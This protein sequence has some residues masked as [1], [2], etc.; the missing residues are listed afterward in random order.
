MQVSVETT[1]GLERRMTITVPA[2]RVDSAVEERLKKAAKTVRIN[3]FRKGKV[4]LKV[5]KKQFGAGVRQ[6]VLGELFGSSFYEAATKEALKPAG[7]PSIEPIKLDEGADIEFAAIFEVFPE[8]AIADLSEL[9]IDTVTAEVAEADIDNMIEVLRKQQASW[10][11]VDRAA[12][13]GDQV[14]IDFAGKKDG[15]LFEGGSAEGQNLVLGSGQM[16]P[17]FES[18]IEGMK[19]GDEKAIEVTFPE[20]YHSEDLKGAAV[21]FTITVHEVQEQELPEINAE[22]FNKFGI[23][24]EEESEFRTEIAQNMKREL[25][26]AVAAKTKTKVM[27]GLEKL[28]SF[29]IPKALIG[30]EINAL[31]QQM[32]QQFGGQQID[33]SMLPDELFQ[34]QAEKRIKVGLVVAEIVA[35][36]D[37]KVDADRVKA[38]VEEVASTYQDAEEV[39]NYYYS[40]KE[41]LNNLESAVLEDQIVDFVLE[42]AA[43]TTSEVSY[44]DAIKPEAPQQ[45]EEA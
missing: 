13:D 41:L 18:G 23:E 4:P 10:A 28:H 42:K 39:I 3:G 34:G 36:N 37:I 35:A 32:A 19:A 25:D 26:N 7:Q 29:D 22:F 15:E 40:N 16:I 27:D 8:I 33:P 2:E 1:T 14:K 20:D 9:Q 17:G 5:V 11:T 43:V 24:T 6:E 44:D 30:N 12:K 21:E 31:R 38:K 45:E